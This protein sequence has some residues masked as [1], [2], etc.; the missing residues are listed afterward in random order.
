[1]REKG[2]G[3]SK[4]KFLFPFFVLILKHDRKVVDEK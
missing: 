1:M 2:N 4:E 3:C